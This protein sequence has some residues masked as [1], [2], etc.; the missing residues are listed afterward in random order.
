MGHR[1]DP[2]L[3][4]RQVRANC[5]DQDQ[6]DQGLHCLPFRLHR[7]YPLLCS[8]QYCSNFR[9]ITAIFSCVRIFRTFTVFKAHK[10]Q[11]KALCN[12]LILEMSQLMRLRYLSH[13]RPAKAQASLHGCAVSPVFTVRTH[14]VW[15]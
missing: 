15:K 10:S 2:K 8:N 5:V 12:E 9:I 14:A 4:D 6:T 1:N 13:R 3:L 11:Y 7:L